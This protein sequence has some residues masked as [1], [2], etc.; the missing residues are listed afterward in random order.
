MTLDNAGLPG[1]PDLSRHNFRAT[2]EASPGVGWSD[3]VRRRA[4][5]IS[6]ICGQT[7]TTRRDGRPCHGAGK[8]DHQTDKTHEKN[9]RESPE[10]T[11]ANPQKETKET[12]TEAHLRSL[13]WLLCKTSEHNPLCAPPKEK[14]EQL[15]AWVPDGNTLYL[16]QVKDEGIMF[17]Y[18]RPV[19]R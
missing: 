4:H 14:G 7:L 18:R 2:A 11:A 19:R 15:A 6:I 5:S 9:P 1:K 8:C 3:L 12:K 16:F 17:Y 10:R 13:R